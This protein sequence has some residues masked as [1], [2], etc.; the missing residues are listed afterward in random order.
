MISRLRW[1]CR[2]VL[3]FA[4]LA[5]ASCAMERTAADQAQTARLIPQA[6]IQENVQR[7]SGYM[8]AT[9]VDTMRPLFTSEDPAIRLAASRHLA[10]NIRAAVDIA[11]GPEPEVNLLDMAAFVVLCRIVIDDYY[12]PK[13]YG[14]EGEALREVFGQLERSIWG[15]AD[16]VLDEKGQAELLGLILEW[17]RENPTVVNVGWVRLFAFSEVVG[18]SAEERSVKTRGLLSSIRDATRTGDRALLLGERAAFLMQRLPVLAGIQAHVTWQRALAELSFAMSKSEGVI[19]EIQSI[20]SLLADA[21]QLTEDA[22]LLVLESK[23]L[24]VTIDGLFPTKEGPSSLQLTKDSLE[25]A[26][27]LAEKSRALTAEIR[28]SSDAAARGMDRL[29]VDVNRVVGRLAFYLSLVG[30]LWAAFFWDGYYFVK[31]A[32]A[33]KQK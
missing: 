29:T 7:F 28:E 26:I 11:T 22:R 8:I 3:P 18:R 23:D 5:L 2:A 32:L 16:P 10:G 30:A 14:A 33:R 6:E 19:K 25:I 21:A 17:R 27:E 9:L 4:V 13:I 31:H 24:A 20:R 12:L 15:I 1:G